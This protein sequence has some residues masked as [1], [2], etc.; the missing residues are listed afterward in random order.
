M[1]RGCAEPGGETPHGERHE[2]QPRTRIAHVS[3]P[4]LFIT[5]GTRLNRLML[6]GRFSMIVHRDLP[7]E[8]PAAVG[9]DDEL[10]GEDVLVDEA[11]A[12]DVEQ[13]RAPEG[14]EAVRVGAAEAEHDLE[15][16]RVGDARGVADEG[17]LVGGARG[18]L[19][20]DDQVGRA[21]LEDLDGALVEVGVAE[22]DLVA[23]DDV[24]AGQQDALLEGL[25]VVRLAHR[26]DLHL[27]VG[28]IGVLRR[29]LVPDLD[30]CG[31]WSRS[32]PG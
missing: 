14:L 8:H 4:R 22:V 30:R 31:P 6:G 23:D 10:A 16:R 19:A 11:R 1:C 2:R 15:E 21:G 24:A 17:A 18:E 9:A 27:A 25:A 28:R 5:F 12:H 29:Q 26:D 20:A 7:D 32:R 13:R 3:L